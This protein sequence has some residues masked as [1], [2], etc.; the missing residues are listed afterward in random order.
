MSQI[1]QVQTETIP[2]ENQHPVRAYLSLGTGLLI[3][4][5]SAILIRVADAPGPVSGMYRMLIGWVVLSGMILLRR[6][7]LRYTRKGLIW[8]AMAGIAIGFDMTFWSTG[9]MMA[10]PTLP[11][12]LG[13]TTPLWV[14]L[15]VMVIY[16]E[17]H[18]RMF[19][20]GLLIALGGAV[21][22]LGSAALFEGALNIGAMLGLISAV[23][24]SAYFMI[25]QRARDFTDSLTSLWLVS[26][27]GG[28]VQLGASLVLGHPLTGYSTKTYLIFLVMGVVIQ[29]LA[30]LLVTYAQGH[31]PASVVAPTLLG[32]PVLTAIFAVPILGERLELI[33]ILGGMAVLGGVLLVHFSKQNKERTRVHTSNKN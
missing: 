28:M 10:G 5:V 17:K 1:Q 4:G 9:I 31:I 16:K 27:F 30:W 3:L 32:Q 2:A 29:V 6:K 18:P 23:F 25:L 24:Y 21:V 15:A 7:K 22:I 26:F 12:L 13:N 8:A 14:G 20:V 33:D 11:T 19:W